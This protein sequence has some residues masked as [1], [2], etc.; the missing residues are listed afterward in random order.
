[1]A[2]NIS[3]V[4]CPQCGRSAIQDYYY[5]TDE[6]YIQCIRCGFTYSRTI[7][8]ENEKE[9]IFDEV[10]NKG[11]GIACIVNH[12]GRRKT[13]LL[14]S[15]LSPELIEQFK[16]DYF[17]SNADQKKSYLVSFNDKDCNVLFGNPPDNFFLP[18]N[19]YKEKMRKK[20]GDSEYFDVLVPLD[21]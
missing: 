12:D 7:K 8:I 5:K 20:Y 16:S 3:A 10:R 4:E 9:I 1:M 11:Y 18:F 6:V 14:G 21:E 17:S 2:S 19:L 13:T 15:E